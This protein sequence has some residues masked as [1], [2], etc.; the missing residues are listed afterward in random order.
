[1]RALRLKNIKTLKLLSISIIVILSILITKL[2]PA[3]SQNTQTNETFEFPGTESIPEGFTLENTESINEKINTELLEPDK[4]NPF[5][6]F[7]SNIWVQILSTLSLFFSFSLTFINQWLRNKIDELKNIASKR[8]E[9]I[10]GFT[11]PAKLEPNTRINSVMVLGLG[12]SGK[13]SLCKAITDDIT[14]DPSI[15]TG[16]FKIYNV[17]KDLPG[18]NPETRCKFYLADYPGQSFL[19]EL[20]AGFIEEQSRPYSPMRYG[21]INSLILVVDLFAPPDLPGEPIP[22]DSSFNKKRIRE[23]LQQWNEQALSA[24]FGM[25]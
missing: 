21:Y 1:M 5:D 20:V 15:K 12:G 25:N 14:A 7:W 22:K 23:N 11:S 2:H 9:E 24:V 18:D 19:E 8:L 16:H 4:E 13:T 10:R 17:A 6:Q 3:V